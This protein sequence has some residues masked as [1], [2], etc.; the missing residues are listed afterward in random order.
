LVIYCHFSLGAA[1]NFP[2]KKGGTAKEKK[3][4]I[5]AVAQGKIT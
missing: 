5:A 4:L 3:R 1:M 2:V